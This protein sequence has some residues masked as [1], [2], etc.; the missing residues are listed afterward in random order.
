MDKNALA[1]ELGELGRSDA[2]VLA[3]LIAQNPD[4][5][6]AAKLEANRARRCEILTTIAN[7]SSA[8]LDATVTTLS[9]EPKK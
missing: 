5:K 1:L 2:K 3:A 4:S 6:L 8:G 7:H 9:V